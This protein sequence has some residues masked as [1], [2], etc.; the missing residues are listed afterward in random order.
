MR[1]RLASLVSRES[2]TFS[3]V[4]GTPALIPWKPSSAKRIAKML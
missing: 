4:N 2:A 1:S 3:G